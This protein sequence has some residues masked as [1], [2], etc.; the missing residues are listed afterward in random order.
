MTQLEQQ[1]Q[2]VA[3]EYIE[4]VGVREYKY[5][6]GGMPEHIA[7]HCARYANE[8]LR[9]FAKFVEGFESSE[10]PEAVEKFI[11]GEI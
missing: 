6:D 9:L 2:Q 7:L 3:L 11:N 5:E 8:R 10:M 1:Q 4:S